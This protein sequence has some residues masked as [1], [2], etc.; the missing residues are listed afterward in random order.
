MV[1]K[2][3]TCRTSKGDRNRST[4]GG[5]QLSTGSPRVIG[6]LPADHAAPVPA[7]VVRCVR[8]SI[9][10]GEI[11]RTALLPCDPILT[12]IPDHGYGERTRDK[13]K[14]S[15]ARV[16]RKALR[17]KWNFTPS[18]CRNL[19]G[20]QICARLMHSL[21]VPPHHPVPRPRLQVDRAAA[22]SSNLFLSFFLFYV[23]PNQ[24]KKQK[25]YTNR[26]RK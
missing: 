5:A 26:Q 2:N 8:P 3:S 17:N 19:R 14:K 7:R 4:L 15:S 16:P 6:I 20:T 18:S 24:K 23:T 10:L 9:Q 21:L 22:K 1:V 25:K 13:E 12:G 11:P